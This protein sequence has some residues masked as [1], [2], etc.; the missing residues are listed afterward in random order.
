MGWHTVPKSDDW[1]ACTIAAAHAARQS[2]WVHCACG[3]QRFVEPEALAA[4]CGVA[5]ETPLLALAMR[6]RCSS[7]REKRVLVWHAPMRMAR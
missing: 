5:V 4:E 7:C 2:L 6:L 1:K 3:R